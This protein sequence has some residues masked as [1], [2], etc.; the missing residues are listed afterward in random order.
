M[1]AKKCADAPP[2]P[3]PRARA[4]TCYTTGEGDSG[5]LHHLVQRNF[6]C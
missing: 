3:E 1:I 2:S 6:A 5:F 4:L